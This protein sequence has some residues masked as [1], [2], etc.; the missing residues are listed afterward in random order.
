M[1]GIAGIV[2]NCSYHGNIDEMLDKIEH[3]GPDGRGLWKNNHVTLGHVRLKIIDLTDRASQPMIDEET[4]NVL[5]FNGEIYNYIELKRDLSNEYHFKTQSDTEV[6]LA[7]YRKWKQNCF[8]HL[9]GMFAFALWDAQKNKILLARD[10]LGI[11][12][13]YY[14]KGKNYFIF[15]S[16]IKALLNIG[17]LTYT[18]N[19]D[20]VLEFL[21]ARHQDCD[22]STFFADIWQVL[23]GKYCWIN[24]DGQSSDFRTF[25]KPGQQCGNQ[26]FNQEAKNEFRNLLTDNVKLH[27]RADVPVGAFVSGGLDSSTI[28]CVASEHLDTGKLHTFS[29]V[30]E[31][32]NEENALIPIVQAKV[33]GINH[34]IQL[35][36]TGFL[37]TL[38]KLLY[39]QDEP[40]AD[41][42]MYAHYI[43]CK[44]AGE[45]GVKVLLSGNGGDEVFGGYPCHVYAYLGSL[46][47]R[48]KLS[49]LIKEIDKLNKN[50]SESLLQLWL[51]SFQEITPFPLRSILKKQLAK[52]FLK[53][54][55]LQKYLTNFNFYYARN[56]DP[57]K[58]NYLNN[59]CHWTVPPFLHYED[60]NSMAF[61]VEIRVPFL[62]HKLLE[63][64][65][66]FSPEY[67]VGNQTKKIIRETM[68][69]FVP[70]E[71]LSQKSKCAFAAPLDIFIRN[72]AQNFRPI[73]RETLR[74]IP[75]L[76]YRESVII[77]ENYLNGISE[78]LSLFWRIFCLA[79]WY[80]IFFNK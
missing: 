18:Y 37:E 41:G 12:P 3:R 13:L 71:V 34:E 23:P 65:E 54:T 4:K 78:N 6:I 8:L 66:R 25:W 50:S 59:I 55:Y 70:Q 9:R 17:D 15:G 39:H 7:A 52:K 76:N 28:A 63:F 45:Q 21:V 73:L 40:I 49:K 43:L 11:K 10:R 32:K 16:E 74:D 44:M 80:N 30:L 67:L 56:E 58:A 29:S 69:G 79:M 62:D 42:S 19:P 26:P 36:G 47:K 31:E 57:W 46:L 38:P 5:V 22:E 72:N 14:R 68:T 64:V 27:L 35:D 1:C 48:R 75:F 60:R 77:C 24:A 51:R 2:G 33:S 53:S 20:R 61:G